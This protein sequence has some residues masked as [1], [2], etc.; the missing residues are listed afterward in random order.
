MKRIEDRRAEID[1]ID[2]QLLRLLNR[3]AQLA[4][5]IGR[6]KRDAGLPLCAPTRERDVLGRVAQANAGPLDDSAVERFFQL[7]IRE[8]RRIEEHHRACPSLRPE[9]PR[10][11]IAK[12]KPE[13]AWK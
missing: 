6:L 1:K 8:S 10:P 7:V 11:G 13:E 4:I 12:A 2:A 5:E 3:R 9:A